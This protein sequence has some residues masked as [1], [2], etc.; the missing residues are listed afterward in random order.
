MA[1]VGLRRTKK[2]ESHQRSSQS[3]SVHE[4]RVKPGRVC[5]PRL[6]GVA[7]R[8]VGGSAASDTDTRHSGALVT[9]LVMRIHLPPPGPPV[10]TAVTWEIYAT[11]GRFMAL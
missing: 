7:L 8:R 6:A 9:S 11:A 1:A 2:I 10:I 4:Q 5:L 3:R